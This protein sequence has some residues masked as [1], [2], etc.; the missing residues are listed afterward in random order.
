[1][2]NS[3]PHGMPFGDYG[4]MRQ[5]RRAKRLLLLGRLELDLL[6]VKK[7][8]LSL[9]WLGLTNLPDTLCKLAQQLLIDTLKLDQSRRFTYG[10]NAIRNRYQHRM[11]ESK[12]HVQ[13]LV[14]TR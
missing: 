14:R 1:M 12:A 13:A 10:L 9:V 8:T 6:V 3:Q 2:N 7:D 4:M 11:G 5:G